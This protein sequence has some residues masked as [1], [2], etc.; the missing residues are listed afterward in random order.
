MSDAIAWLNE[1]NGAVIAL[2]TLALVAFNGVL[3]W[4]GVRRHT[5]FKRPHLIAY[6]AP[7]PAIGG[8]M[9][10]VVANIGQGTAL[11]IELSN[12]LKDTE[13]GH[14][15]IPIPGL[16]GL[17][18]ISALLGGEQIRIA[19]GFGW[20]LL[21][22]KKTSSFGVTLRYRGLLPRSTREESFNISIEDWAQF[23]SLTSPDLRVAKGI[24]DISTTFK[25]YVHIRLKAKN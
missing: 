12:S 14:L 4:I 3:T 8:A 22:Q 16:N 13:I 17:R 20:E 24:E 23:I 10:L 6:A 11:Q 2:L 5:A 21:E 7:D 1:N 9:H 15:Q 19:M 25:R 18:S